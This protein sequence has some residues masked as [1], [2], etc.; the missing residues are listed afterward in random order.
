MAYPTYIT[1]ALVCGTYDSQG[2]DRSFLLFTREAGMI[3][4]HAKSVREEYSKQRYALQ[5]CSHARV[6]LIRGKSGWKIAG[7]EPI[8]NLYTLAQSRESRAFLRTI[9]LLLKRVVHGETV[10][11]EI[12][13]DVID[14]CVKS[15]VY[16]QTK[17]ESILSLRILHALGYIAPVPAFDAILHC[18]MPYTIVSGLSESEEKKCREA[19]AYA[20]MQSQL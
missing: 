8:Q 16:T 10:Y 7:T 13:D 20:L 14:A 18:A 19:V 11:A 1:E 12:F 6:T 4:A 5:E 15:D 9:V 17:L 3:Y 2:A